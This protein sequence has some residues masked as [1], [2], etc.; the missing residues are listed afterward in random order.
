M[1]FDPARQPR[2]TFC[3]RLPRRELLH[4]VGGGFTSL[5]LSGLMSAAG[6]LRSQAVAADAATPW[7]TP[8]A[9]KA[10]PIPAQAKNVIL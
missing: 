1:H 6:V 10:P 2:N 4:Q 7:Q 5:A 8:M 3:G 9:V